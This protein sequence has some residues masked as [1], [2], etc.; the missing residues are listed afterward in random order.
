MIWFADLHAIGGLIPLLNYLKH[1][2]AGVRARAAEVLSTIVQNNPKSQQQVMQVNGL[3][4][5][6]ENFT[7]DDN[8]TVRTK[9]LGAISCKYL[10]Q[11]KLVLHCLYVMG[12]STLLN[13]VGKG[14]RF[15]HYLALTCVIQLTLRLYCLSF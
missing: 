14:G 1:P 4:V 9:A 8:M 2:Q 6:L 5:L 10:L 15:F 7:S 11:P 12:A 3:E 13:Q